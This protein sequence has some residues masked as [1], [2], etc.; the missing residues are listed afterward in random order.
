VKTK[1]GLMWSNQVDGHFSFATHNDVADPNGAWNVSTVPYSQI[2]DDHI[3]LKTDSAGRV[4]ATVKSSATAAN[5]PLVS[6][7]VRSAA[8]T[9]AEHTAWLVKD[10]PT[11]P[12]MLLDEQQHR[13]HVFA[14]GPVPDDP[15]NIDGML[16]SKTASTDSFAF[17]DGVG[18]PLMRD[19]TTGGEVHDA[20]STKQNVDA[21]TGVVVLGSNEIIGS[22]WFSDSRSTPLSP[23]S[24]PPPAPGPPPPAAP[25]PP[26]SAPPPPPSAPPTAPTLSHLVVA[27]AQR[28]TTVRGRVTIG[29]AGSALRVQLRPARGSAARAA[30]LGQAARRNVRAGALRFSVP[31]T[32]RAR[33]A[34]ARRGRLRLRLRLTV[35]P[36]GGRSVT[37]VRRVL[38]RRAATR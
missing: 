16:Y 29:L 17:G 32:R 30:S 12:T 11:R 20:T 31:L 7:L 24:P 14:T 2:A 6:V 28:G 8:G 37:A 35:T 4:Y 3:N 25:P 36:R 19:M 22:Y 5:A 21:T 33:A 9:W 34:L 26:P 38:V 27:P 13:V 10:K 23:S 18:T 15:A 1:W